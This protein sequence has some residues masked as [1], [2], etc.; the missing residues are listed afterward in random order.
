MVD[1]GNEDENYLWIDRMH[2]YGS[3]MR[4]DY[5]FSG[6]RKVFY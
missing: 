1:G 4:I 2:N 6:R 3:V 5:Y